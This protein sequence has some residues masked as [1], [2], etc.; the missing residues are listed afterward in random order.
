[1]VVVGNIYE[2]P[3][4]GTFVARVLIE[5]AK[6]IPFNRQSRQGRDKNAKDGNFLGCSPKSVIG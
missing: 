5:L 4:F 2:A 6:S 3:R 1:M